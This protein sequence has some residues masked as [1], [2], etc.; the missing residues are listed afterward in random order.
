MG[1]VEAFEAAY[2]YLDGDDVHGPL[3]RAQ[4]DALVADGTIDDGTV[5]WSDDP[6]DVPSPQPEE[7][8]SAGGRGAAA[9]P[10]LA[11]WVV[12]LLALLEGIYRLY[13]VPFGLHAAAGRWSLVAPALAR[14][15]LPGTLLGHAQLQLLVGGSLSLVLAAALFN[16]QRWAWLALALMLA[17]EAVLTST[18]KS[19]LWPVG[20]SRIDWPYLGLV[21]ALLGALL[22]PGSRAWFAIDQ[23]EDGARADAASPP[24]HELPPAPLAV[25]FLVLTLT[26]AVIGLGVV[27]ALSEWGPAPFQLVR[28]AISIAL[29]VAAWKLMQGLLAARA[30]A[31]YV[32]L[33][34]AG[35]NALFAVGGGQAEGRLTVDTSRVVASAAWMW[36]V[37]MP[38]TRAWLGD[39]HASRKRDR[40][41]RSAGDGAP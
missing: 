34:L 8:S 31:F 16:R 9:G 2:W 23:G 40:R 37:F 17:I 39:V 41:A 14:F 1:E 29:A 3:S 22:L 18:A 32:C 6:E 25:W 36:A 28:F 35:L 33:G 10:P 12:V 30:G 5:W 11:V 38:S 24:A 4:Y 19:P 21:L 7:R 15:D 13:I 20:A 27:G 26:S